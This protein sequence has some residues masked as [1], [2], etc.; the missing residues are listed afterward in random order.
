MTTDTLITPQQVLNPALELNRASFI[1]INPSFNPDTS[2]SHL[3]KDTYAVVY[4]SIA[5][6]IVSVPGSRGRIFQEDYD[7]GVMSMLQEPMDETTASFMSM[8]L[9]TAIRRWE[10]R[11]DDVSVQVT[12]KP[13]L[14]GYGI[15]VTGRLKGISDSDFSATYS[16]P[17]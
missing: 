4:G 13:S 3:I 17:I 6:L 15:Y 10:P 1:D 14:P 7:G 12:P 9:T 8:G 16:L 5:N 2:P 11:I